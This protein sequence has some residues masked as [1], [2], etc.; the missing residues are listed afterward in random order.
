[1][2]DSSLLLESHVRGPKVCDAMI[3]KY[4]HFI[5][6]TGSLANENDPGTP[7]VVRICPILGIGNPC[8][9]SRW[10]IEVGALE[11]VAESLGLHN[12]HQSGII[13]WACKYITEWKDIWI[14]IKTWSFATEYNPNSLVPIGGWGRWIRDESLSVGLGWAVPKLGYCFQ[15]LSINPFKIRVHIW[16]VL[17]GKGIQRVWRFTLG[18]WEVRGGLWWG[19]YC[20]VGG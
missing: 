12:H 9:F 18:R 3:W 6:N 4:L 8:S 16:G 13:V 5:E 14:I 10:T 7:T 15:R 17:E 11:G 20:Q 2:Q 19:W 1:M